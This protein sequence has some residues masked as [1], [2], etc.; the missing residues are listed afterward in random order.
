VASWIDEEVKGGA[1]I[2][3]GGGR[4]SQTTLEKTLLLDPPSNARLSRE[5]IFGPAVCVYRYTQLDD[6]I[7]RSNALP[8]AFQAS[9][10]RRISGSRCVP[11]TG[12]M[13]LLS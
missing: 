6:A 11:P 13:R 5:E 12:L 8:V 9:V 7:A 10:L 4:I 3:T 2:A 1:R